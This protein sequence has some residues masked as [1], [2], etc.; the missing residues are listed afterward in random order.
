MKIAIL[1]CGGSFGLSLARVALSREI[2]VIGIGRSPM[3]PACFSLQFAHPVRNF[4]YFPYHI[5]YELDYVMRLLEMEC[6]ELIVSFAAQGEGAASFDPNDYWRFYD[7]NTTACVKLVGSL[8]RKPWLKRFIQ[9]G[10][11]EMYGSADRP[12]KETDP[13]NPTS[14]YA[15]SKVAFDLH[16]LSVFKNRDFPM[17]I[18]RPTNCYTVGQ[19]LHR[20]IPRTMLYGMT[21]KKL[22]LHGGGKAE[23]SYLYADDL[24][25]AI[26]TVHEKAPLGEIYNCGPDKPTSI[27]KVVEMCCRIMGV[28]FDEF[29]EVVGER[30]GQDSRYW[31][32]SS[33]LKSLGWKQ[34]VDWDM[35]LW[36]MRQWIEAYKPELLEQNPNFRMRA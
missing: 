4:K 28:G 12:M 16:L 19:Q 33:K 14:P 17:N 31:L 2:E 32:D 27:R 24:A 34:E 7:T 25:N 6:P 5:N 22:E 13:I 35:G 21:K 23:K 18:I 3:K 36:R 9:I 10:T 8:E 11:S 30:E 20:I 29:V 1:G 15:A 26:L